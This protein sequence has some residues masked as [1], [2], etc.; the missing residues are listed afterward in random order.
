M[1]QRDSDV[2]ENIQKPVYIPSEKGE[3]ERGKQRDELVSSQIDRS[4]TRKDG[5]WD[6]KTVET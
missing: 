3:E 4:D 2:L 5:F 1:S 6:E